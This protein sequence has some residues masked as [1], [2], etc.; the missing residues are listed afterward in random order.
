MWVSRR[1]RDNPF[2]MSADFQAHRSEKG[3]A[4]HARGNLGDGGRRP[5]VP[6]VSHPI[7]NCTGNCSQKQPGVEPP[8]SFVD[9]STRPWDW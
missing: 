3:Q 1:L 7:Q 5:F 8:A 6:D 4:R 9:S 2:T